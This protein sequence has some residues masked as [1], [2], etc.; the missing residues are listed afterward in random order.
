MFYISDPL[1]SSH[2]L[3]V[4]YIS[5]SSYKFSF[6]VYVLHLLILLQVLIL[7]LYFIS[8]DPLISFHSLVCVLYLL[9]LLQVL[10]LSLC[11]TSADPLISSHSLSMFYISWSSY[12][13]SFSVYIHPISPSWDLILFLCVISFPSAPYRVHCFVEVIFSISITSAFHGFW[14]SVYV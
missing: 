7:C 12:K 8:P 10:I 2:S 13:F 4:F 9:I 6:S 14:F 1:T 3:S 11:S 5:R